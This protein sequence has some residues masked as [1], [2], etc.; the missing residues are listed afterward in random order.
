MSGRYIYYYKR[1]NRQGSRL[2]KSVD[3]AVRNAVDDVRMS[4]TNPVSVS[5][6]DGSVIFDTE[7]LMERV[8]KELESQ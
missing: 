6:L 4:R 5:Y 8:R 1:H 2:H 7:A 3:D